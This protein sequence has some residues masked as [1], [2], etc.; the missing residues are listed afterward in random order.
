M[1]QAALFIRSRVQMLAGETV[2]PGRLTNHS[3]AV[4]MMLNV[5]FLSKHGAS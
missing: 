4:N 2:N 5:Q 3:D 1:F